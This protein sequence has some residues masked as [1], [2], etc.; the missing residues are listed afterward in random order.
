MWRGLTPHPRILGDRTIVAV[1]GTPGD[2]S[3][4]YPVE[5]SSFDSTTS[6]INWV[7]DV[8]HPSSVIRHLTNS[9]PWAAASALPR[10]VPHSPMGTCGAALL[11]TEPRTRLWLR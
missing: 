10:L 6:L 1:G 5:D 3:V 4:A 2:K 8:R 7:P 11:Q 9:I